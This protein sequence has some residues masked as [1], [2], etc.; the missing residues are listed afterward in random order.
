MIITSQQ[1]GELMVNKL[2]IP[3]VKVTILQLLLM[4]WWWVIFVLSD[5]PLFTCKNNFQLMVGAMIGRLEISSFEVIGIIRGGIFFKFLCCWIPFHLHSTT[6]GVLYQVSHA[7]V[8]PQMQRLFSYIY[9]GTQ[10]RAND[11]A[12][13]R[14]MHIPQ[15]WK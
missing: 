3:F 15:K 5:K 12:S 4:I 9:F 2:L 1:L 6:F 10:D 14:Y 13:I 8:N 11:F 7:H